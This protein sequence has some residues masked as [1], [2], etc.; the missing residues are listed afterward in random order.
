VIFQFSR[1][2]GEQYTGGDEYGVLH[3][4]KCGRRSYV[5]EVTEDKGIFNFET[6]RW[7]TNPDLAAMPVNEFSTGA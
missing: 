4:R 7:E 2:P 5:V 3:C 1:N 6:K